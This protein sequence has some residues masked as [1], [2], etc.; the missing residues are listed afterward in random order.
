M[1]KTLIQVRIA[2]TPYIWFWWSLD[3]I[4]Q[5]S[6]QEVGVLKSLCLAHCYIY[7]QVYHS[8]PFDFKAPVT[9]SPYIVNLVEP[10]RTFKTEHSQTIGEEQ[11]LD[12]LLAMAE[13]VSDKYMMF[14]HFFTKL[15]GM[16]RIIPIILGI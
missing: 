15:L 3:S 12:W 1:L 5:S 16:D 9:P 14:Y 6:I 2:V 11:L 7:F 10:I 4:L 8:F 13:S